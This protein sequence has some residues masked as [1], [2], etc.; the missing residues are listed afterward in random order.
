MSERDVEERV[1]ELARGLRRVAAELFAV[2]AGHPDAARGRELS[3]VA[4]RLVGGVLARLDGGGGT[5]PA[6]PRD[7]GTALGEL[8]ELYLPGLEQIPDEDPVMIDPDLSYGQRGHLHRAKRGSGSP[9]AAAP[10]WTE[11]VPSRGKVVLRG[12]TSHREVLRRMHRSYVTR[13]DLEGPEGDLAVRVLRGCEAIQ[14]SRAVKASDY[15]R[16][17]NL[18]LLM[19]TLQW[20]A[21]VTAAAHG[22]HAHA[23]LQTQLRQLEVLAAAV[24]ELDT[25][26]RQRADFLDARVADATLRV[27]SL[28]SNWPPVVDEA[29]D[30]R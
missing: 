8:V 22:E 4:Q 11:H 26:V 6:G 30:D 19:E 25:A 7:V 5:D 9:F 12:L 17:W 1:G 18:R 20:R 28:L 23:H 27:T 16:A 2:A 13:R 24:L 14:R 29:A 3:A 21:L 15:D 10:L